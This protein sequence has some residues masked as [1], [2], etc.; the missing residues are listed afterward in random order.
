MLIYVTETKANFASSSW[1]KHLVGI[2]FIFIHR[3]P[4]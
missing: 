2:I 4:S 1:T 3:K